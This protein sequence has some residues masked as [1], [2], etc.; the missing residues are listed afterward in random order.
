MKNFH[1]LGSKKAVGDNDIAEAGQKAIS[2]LFHNDKRRMASQKKWD[3]IFKI[4]FPNT[5]AYVNQ[6]IDLPQFLYFLANPRPDVQ[7]EVSRIFPDAHENVS[8]LLRLA[9]ASEA[10]GHGDSEN[11]EITEDFRHSIATP[12]SVAT[13]FPSSGFYGPPYEE[14]Q[15]I[16]G[17]SQ[18][19]SGYVLPQNLMINAI[20]P[21]TEFSYPDID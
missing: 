18:A 1:Y 3:K 20:S 5:E 21:A 17:S 2:A 11:D 19:V 13:D 8:R 9:V 14:Y 4:C 10:S 6:F 16:M 7:T 15:H 12:Q